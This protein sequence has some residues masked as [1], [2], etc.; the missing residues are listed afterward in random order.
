MRR[1]GRLD[2][3]RRLRRSR[4]APAG[5][6]PADCDRSQRTQRPPARP[7]ASRR[8]GSPH[9]RRSPLFLLPALVLYACWSSHPIVLAATLQPL[10][11]ER[12]RPLDKFVGLDNFTRGLRRRRLPRRPRH[13]ASSSSCCR[14]SSSCPFALGLALLLNQRL[15]GR[16][17]LRMLF[18]APYVL[19][20]VVTGVVW[21]LM[22]RP[23]GLLD[24]TLDVGRLPRSRHD[25][26]ADPDIVLYACSS[27]SRGSTSASTWSSTSPACSRS[28]R[29][30]S[31]AA[32]IDGATPLADRSATSRCRCSGPTIRIS[33]LPVDHRRDPAVRPRVG[34]DRR[35]PD[36][37]VVDD[38]GLHVRPRLQALRVRLR[39]RGRVDH[40][41]DLARRSRSPT[42]ASSC[43]ATSEGAM[44]TMG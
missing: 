38:G 19:S 20:E 40:A 8:A 27:S 21:H 25:W 42:S 36:R 34:D 14:W 18:F 12:V 13:N 17:L 23:S 3:P 10:Q 2:R 29:S 41:R 35:R 30:S 9:G 22:L 43:G 5:R 4:R 16:A 31:E 44:T 33:R 26:L 28:P 24:Q 1:T 32:A 11:V 37:R 7:P 39:Q 6:L 15:P